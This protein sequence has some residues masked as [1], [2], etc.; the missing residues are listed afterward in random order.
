[1]MR[2]KIAI[3]LILTT[4]FCSA[5]AGCGNS[6]SPKGAESTK[7]P[8]ATAGSAEADGTPERGEADT[9]EL[10]AG[11]ESE[12]ALYTTVVNYLNNGFHSDDLNGVYD[13]ILTAVAIYTRPSG[14]MLDMNYDEICSLIV[15]LRITWSKIETMLDASENIDAFCDAFRSEFPG[16]L[17]EENV[18]S[19]A[20]LEPVLYKLFQSECPENMQA[21]INE[22]PDRFEKFINAGVFHHPGNI[23]DG[24]NPYNSSQT[25]WEKMSEDAL[26]ISEFHY[27]DG[28]EDLY[29]S[30]PPMYFMGIGEYRDEEGFNYLYEMEILYTKI[31]GRYYLISFTGTVI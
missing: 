5:L 1:M 27:D 15:K 20:E 30:F 31:D 9:Y 28:N 2:K 11:A 4:V 16:Y 26:V 25:E 6:D 8:S 23:R 22:D 13:P 10:P 7:K 17:P 14:L 24:E 12:Y 19:D 18:A 29:N 3:L 21:Q